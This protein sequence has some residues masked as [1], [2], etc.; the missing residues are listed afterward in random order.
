MRSWRVRRWRA[1]AIGGGLA[2]AALLLFF[3]PV[4]VP[5]GFGHLTFHSVG[6]APFWR[7]EGRDASEFWLI[8]ELFLAL[9]VGLFVW[10]VYPDYDPPP[11]P[12]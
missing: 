11:P 7:L 1:A 5:K 12:R 2:L 10:F 6:F 3:F 4:R 8:L 9:A